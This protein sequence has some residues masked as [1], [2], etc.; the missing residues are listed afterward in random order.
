VRIRDSLPPYP[1]VCGRPF[2]PEAHAAFVG[3]LR[4]ALERTPAVRAF[5]GPR[6]AP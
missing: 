6:A 2:A 4:A 3:A 5:V 1:G